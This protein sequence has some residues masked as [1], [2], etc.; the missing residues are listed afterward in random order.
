MFLY[1]TGNHK[2]DFTFEFIDFFAEYKLI[3]NYL[4]VVNIATFIA[5]VIDK[6]N[7]VTNRTRIRIVTLLILSFIGGS[8]GGMLA[9]Y[10]FRHK[11]RKDYFAVG[12]PMILVTQIVLILYVMNI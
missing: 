11:I 10:L 6:Y 7:A 5:F 4:I 9:M 3:T 1:L 2:Q 8:I 12:L